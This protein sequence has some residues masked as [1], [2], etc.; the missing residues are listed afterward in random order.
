MLHKPPIVRLVGLR[1]VS[2]HLLLAWTVDL[3]LFFYR[4]AIY[5]LRL[6]LKSTNQA[7]PLDFVILRSF[8]FFLRPLMESR[9]SC[10]AFL[11]K[12]KKVLFE[13]RLK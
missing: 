9:Y 7:I 6:I 5:K 11:K 2:A 13:D 4:E 12:K 8:F 1:L 10:N 3:F